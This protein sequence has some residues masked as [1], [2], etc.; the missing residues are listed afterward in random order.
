V[1]IFSSALVSG[2]IA[3]VLT[4]LGAAHLAAAIAAGGAVCGGMITLLNTLLPGS[5]LGRSSPWRRPPMEGQ[6]IWRLM[7]TCCVRS[8]ETTSRCV[9]STET[10]S[11]QLT[12][13]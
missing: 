8:A 12:G 13:H 7:S 4:D 10:V 3:G 6:T 11:L 2:T 1:I 5:R 9:R